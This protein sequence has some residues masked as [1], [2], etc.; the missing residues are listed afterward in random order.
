MNKRLLNI[1]FLLITQLFHAQDNEHQIDSVYFYKHYIQKEMK[2]ISSTT[3]KVSIQ[4]M[5]TNYQTSSLGIK[6]SGAQ[7][8]NRFLCFYGALSFSQVI[9]QIITV[10]DSLKVKLTGANFS[11]LAGGDLFN[12]KENI[13]LALL[14]GFEVGRL[15]MYGNSLLRKKNGYFAPK[16]ETLFKVQIKRFVLGACL[17]Y[18]YDIS[19]PN[20]KN[21][22]FSKQKSYHLDK[23]RQ[24]GISMSII[25]GMT[26]FSNNEAY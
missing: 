17:A 9:P 10:N 4:N 18:K 5:N 13:D 22:W 24:N 23:V 11:T 8:V 16:I 3:L 1:L 21:T 25:A 19:N 2:Y 15:R 14:I 20:W 7:G 26:L 12:K 6:T